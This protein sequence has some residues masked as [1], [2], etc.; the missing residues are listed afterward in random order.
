MRSTLALLI[1]S[2]FFSLLLAETTLRAYYT[3]TSTGYLADLVD[4]RPLPP[5]DSELRWVT[6]SR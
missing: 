4:D 1:G 3:A 6:Y 2:I 5:P